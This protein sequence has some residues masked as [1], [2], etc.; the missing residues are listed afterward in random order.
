MEFTWK[1]VLKGTKFCTMVF[2]EQEKLCILNFEHCGY[3]AE[4]LGRFSEY[5]TNM[6]LKVLKGTKYRTNKF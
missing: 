6:A 2:S 4:G 3:V 5:R 1:K